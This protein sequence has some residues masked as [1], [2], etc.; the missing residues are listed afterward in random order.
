MIM[1]LLLHQ[2]FKQV[3]NEDHM[4]SCHKQHMPGMD[5][6]CPKMISTTK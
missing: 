2:V 4:Y 5:Y 3:F 1:S 6:P